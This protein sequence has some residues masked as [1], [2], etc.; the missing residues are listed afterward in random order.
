MSNTEQTEEK[1]K[2]SGKWPILIGLLLA[3]LGAGG[4]FF[5]TTAFP[6]FGEKAEVNQV[7]IAQSQPLETLFMPLDP[8]VIS[9]GPQS[10][11]KHLKFTAHLEVEK[12]F[13]SEVEYL[14]PRIMDALNTYLQA[15]QASDFSNPSTLTRVKGQL[16][17]RIKIIA[18]EGRVRN[19]LIVE[20]V[21]T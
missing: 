18:G 19:I 12:A 6:I 8:L 21:L 14:K 15:V 16:L 5:A 3:I 13:A 11:S 20:F 7:E 1:P 17:R 2:K 10:S 9:L 4:G